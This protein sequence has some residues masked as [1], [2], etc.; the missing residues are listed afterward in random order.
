MPMKILAV[1]HSAV[2]DVYRAKFHALARLGCEVHLA[3]PAGWPEGGR[4]VPAPP[5]GPEAGIEIHVLPVRLAGSVGFSFLPG[6]GALIRR[7]APQIVHSEEAPFSLAARQ[8][9]RVA[10]GLG[11]PTV[12]FTWEN[13]HRRYKF[14]SE[15][16]NRRNLARAS[17]MIAGSRDAEQVLRARGYAG[18]IEVIPQYGVDTQLFQ[19]LPGVR[20]RRDGT[21]TLGYFGRLLEEKG[22]RTLLRACAR[23][24]FPFRLLITGNGGYGAALRRLARELGLEG[25]VEFAPAVD[26]REAPRVLNRLDALVLPSET[27]PQWK[28]QFGRVLIEAMACEVPVIGSDSGEIPRVI[29]GAGLV[30]PE[31]DDAALAALAE[32]LQ[33]EPETAAALA[34]RGRERVLTYFTTARIAERTLGVY[35]RLPPGSA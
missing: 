15:G 28:E 16:I 14:P 1:S 9:L 21:F 19:P 33:R 2:V 27:R 22:V 17:W 11:I 13:L 26:N 8:A 35:R 4:W 5:A 3:V 20:A 18:G 24:E 34:K 29:G 25:R 7:I 6:L 12:C 10:A 30:F 31:G 23:L 32:R